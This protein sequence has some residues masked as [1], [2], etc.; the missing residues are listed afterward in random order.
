MLASVLSL[1][2]PL[3][4]P[5]LGSKGFFIFSKRSNAACQINGN[6]AE[7]TMQAN[8]LPFYTSAYFCEEGRVANKR[9]KV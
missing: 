2:T 5:G 8:I 1:H 9:G 4:P 7:Y 6:E 3:V